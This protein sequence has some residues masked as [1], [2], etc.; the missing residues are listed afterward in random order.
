MPLWCGDDS[1][2]CGRKIKTFA[3]FFIP[4]EESWHEPRNPYYDYYND[5]KVCE[6]M[7]AAFGLDSPQSRIVNGHTP[8]RVTH[9]ES[10]IKAGG[11]LIVIDGGF[12]KAYQKA[13]GIAGYT[14]IANSHGMR[15]MSHHP[16]TTL[17]DA[18][19]ANR[20]IRSQSFDFAVYPRRMLVKDT[21]NGHRLQERIDDLKDL[22]AACRAGI[23]N[24]VK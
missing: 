17:E 11:R 4:D 16:F 8:I 1:P 24:L 5:E 20:D 3:R 12:C 13:T 14:L 15:I 9:G 2:V 23:I 18:L 22:L 19:E 21:D 7:L 6:K 10:P